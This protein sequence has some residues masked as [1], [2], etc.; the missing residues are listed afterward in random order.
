MNDLNEGKAQGGAAQN[1]VRHAFIDRLFH[2]VS[3]TSVL[4]LLLTSFLPIVG[5]K[6][7]WVTLHWVFGLVLTG[8]ITFHLV[9]TVFWQDLSSMWFG[10]KDIRESIVTLAWLLRMKHGT[11]AKSAKYS[12]AQK[13]M[14]HGV[15]AFVLVTILTGLL[16]M[17]KIDTPLWERN[18]YWLSDQNWGLVYVFHGA[19][20]LFLMSIVMVHIYFSFRP[21][22]LMY[23]RSMILGWLTN[24]EFIDHH[25]PQ[26]WRR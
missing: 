17:V 23:T 18:P 1:I 22:K 9:R 20:A 19:A 5:V 7:P 21:E 12:P 15:S 3:A 6:F 25:D 24:E 16:M 26:R 8:A 10:A 13:L 14:H 2:W 4:V 11:P